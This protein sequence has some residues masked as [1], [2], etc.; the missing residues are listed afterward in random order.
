MK[1]KEKDAKR[2]KATCLR[3]VQLW[4]EID[5]LLDESDLKLTTGQKEALINQRRGGS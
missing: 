2:R 1:R 4:L 5:R 3:A